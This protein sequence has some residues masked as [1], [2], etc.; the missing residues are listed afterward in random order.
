MHLQHIYT[1]NS[2]C[3]ALEMTFPELGRRYSLSV[4][5][6]LGPEIAHLA[7]LFARTKLQEQRCGLL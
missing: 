1:F 5:F 2:C 3:N 7:N 4:S 6:R